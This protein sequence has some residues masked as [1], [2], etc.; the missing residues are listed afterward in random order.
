M[1]LTWRA[2][3]FDLAFVK[4]QSGPK[5]SWIGHQIRAAVK[6]HK[7]H[8]N[9]KDEFLADLATDTGKVLKRNTI[10]YKGLKSYTGRVGHVA[11]LMWVWRPFVDPLWAAIYTEGKPNNGSRAPKGQIW[12][13]QVKQ[14]VK[15]V[16]TFLE[17]SGNF[18][19]RTWSLYAHFGSAAQLIIVFDASP[20]GL[21]A[22]LYQDGVPVAW[23]A[24]ALDEHDCRSFGVSI[25]DSDGQQIWECLAVLAALR[26]WF[27]YWTQSR[28]TMGFRESNHWRKKQ[29]FR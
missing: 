12:V 22:V 17:S 6:D 8:V 3:G 7:V 21:G 24:N 9:I 10:T 20:W 4:G 15:W 5:V 27:P 29:R 14:S 19:S 11:N 2:L 1:F 25:W 18:V 26:A 23:I 16:R 28:F 13:A